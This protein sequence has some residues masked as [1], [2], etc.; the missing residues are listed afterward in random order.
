M[1]LEKTVLR[2]ISATRS[3]VISVILLATAAT[4]AFAGQGDGTRTAQDRSRISPI[5]RAM[6]A[7]AQMKELEQ[8]KGAAAGQGMNSLSSVREKVGITL[9]D[10]TQTSSTI[11]FYDNAEG[12]LN[13]W[14]TALYGGTTDD[15]WHQ[16]TVDASSATHSWWPG[17]DVDTNYWTGRRINTAAITPAIDLTTAVAPLTLLFTENFYTERGWDYCM[18]DVSTDGGANW[19]PL[20]GVYGTA[21]SGVTGG[22]RITTLD[23]SAYAGSTLN[24]RFYFDTGD[25]LFNAFPGW[26]VDDVM[27]FDQ[28]GLI[29]GKKYFDVNSNGTKDAGERG[30]GDW[31]ITATGPVTLTTTT[32]FH[33]RYWLNLPL[34]NYTVSEEHQPGWT[35]TAP[36]SGT[37][38]ISMLTADTVA[39]NTNF[40]N[41]RQASWIY[42]A[43]FHDLNKNGFRDGGDTL[44]SGWRITLADTNNIRV[45]Y[46][47]TDS[48]GEYGLPVFEPGT[49][50]V[51]ERDEDF[52]VQTYPPTERYTITIP[53]L[54]TTVNLKDFGNYYSDSVNSIFGRKFNDLN[55]NGVYDL[56]EPG[57]PG[58]EMYLGGAKSRYRTTD[59]SGYYSFT[60]LPTG[61]YTVKE[62][63][64]DG[65]WPSLP[66]LPETLYS[67]FLSSGTYIDSVNFGNYEIVP[68]SISGSKWN[69]LNDNGVRDI[70]E[71]GLANWK[72]TLAG[73]TTATAYTD[74]NG[75]YTFPGLWPGD[76]MVS[77]SWRPFWRQT[78][79]PNLG[80]HGFVL[81]PEQD[82]TGIS[83][84]NTVDSTFSTTFRT[85]T[86]DSLA[87][88]KDK[89]NRTK[90]VKPVPDKVEFSLVF[91]NEEPQSVV[92]IF[93]KFTNAV[94]DTPTFNR[95]GT[96]Q[97]GGR[98]KIAV[99]TLDAPIPVGDTLIVSGFGKKPIPQNVRRWYWRRSDFSQG[100]VHFNGIFRT[101]I[102]RYPMPNTI[103]L[104]QEV[105]PG[106]RIGLGGAHT[107]VHNTYRALLKSMIE[108]GDRLHIGLP[109][110]LDRFE[111]TA[112]RPISR[113]RRY[114]MPK[115][116][117]N[118]LFGEAIALKVNIR[119]SDNLNMPAGFG[120]LIYDEGTGGA[121]PLNGMSVREIS[122]LLDKYMSSFSDTAFSPSCA[123]IPEWA[124]LDV[125]TLYNRI[126][127]I[128]SS[129][130]G[131]LD[132][133][134]FSTGLVFSGVGQIDDVPW[135]R[136]DTST[137]L[138]PRI[139][140]EEI[141]EEVPEQFDLSQNYPNPFNPTTTVEYFLPEAS[142]VTVTIY[143]TLG[144]V[145][146]RVLDNELQEDGYQEVSIDASGL[147]SGIYFYRLAAKTT[148][149]PEEETA[150]RSFS[151]VK[152]MV[153]MK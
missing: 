59:D 69:D 68:G 93:M 101:N 10:A 136:L 104:I 81:G 16:T 151:M 98:N 149:D 47:V 144:Q 113:Q 130:S 141:W 120:D 109:R 105:A 85:F 74:V 21:P 63:Q 39:A 117:N 82:V 133:V 13:G 79:P 17:I 99:I 114:L 80:T 129:F 19:A 143:N 73:K 45:R 15:I 25:T 102:L 34:G 152:K 87:L 11:F 125:D 115:Q 150:P 103:N 111:G 147:S 142:T 28:G 9:N 70:G 31:K 140:H 65:W 100:L 118:V 95:N 51:R 94:L 96:V 128:N 146:A 137:A 50:I 56:H 148:G 145:V 48:L 75:D 131:P 127:R 92:E 49:Y 27:V 61:I 88:G 8:L 12:G 126:R 57:V 36:P 76:Y 54:F 20:R 30:V 66:A 55:R 78:Y 22:W 116:H 106:L 24:V 62:I 110:C 42:G 29:T 6:E 5:R 52:W 89:R 84:G 44:L 121:L 72:I 41:W 91:V 38:F 123:M 14:T 40:G 43:K 1:I 58:F 2:S 53:D 71:P 4:F 108:R 112:Q 97:M 35:Q 26:F 64:Q 139:A 3:A 60:G 90:P 153:V 135:L 124:G 122:G 86:Y 33:G 138:H 7:R 119:G 67:F 107:V 23:L 18:V 32:N 46:D 37:W 134:S 132:T 83:F 77:E